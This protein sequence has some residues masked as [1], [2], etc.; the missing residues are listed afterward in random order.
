MVVKVAVILSLCLESSTLNP[1]IEW[2][3]E[4]IEKEKR[5]YRPSLLYVS[6]KNS[7]SGGRFPQK[8]GF[9]KGSFFK[10]EP[11]GLVKSG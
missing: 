9:H 6:R 3:I 2:V 8:S 4:R 5:S 10:T 1:A 7:V 11:G